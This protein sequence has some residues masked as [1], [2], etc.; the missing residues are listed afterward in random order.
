MRII[1]SD[2]DGTVERFGASRRLATRL[3]AL[4]RRGLLL[5]E[6]LVEIAADEGAQPLR[7]LLLGKPLLDAA[8]GL[9]DK[10]LKKLA[11]GK[12][13]KDNPLAVVGQAGRRVLCLT[14]EAEDMPEPAATPTAGQIV[15]AS[16]NLPAVIARDEARRLL[17]SE[18]VSRLKLDLVTS[19]DAGRRLEALRKLYLSEL[20]PDEKLR[21]FLTA[22]RD[23]DAEVRAEAARALG[24]LGL[25]GALTENLAKA[26]RGATPERVVAI[27]NL[28]R[29]LPRLDANQGKLA[30][31]LL[32]EF[33]A[34]SEEVEVVHAAMGVLATRLAELP[35]GEAIA[36]GLHRKLIELLQVQFARHEDAAR[37]LY[38]ALYKQR[39]AALSPLLVH[40]IDEAGQPALRFFLLSLITEHDLASAAAP[41]VIAL[42]IEG[43]AIGSELDRNYQAATA[44]LARLGERAVDGLL[45][46]LGKGGDNVR[47]RIV[48]L[49]GHLL[50]AGDES[51]Y[52]VQ[53]T[54][55]AR[56]AQ[57]CLALYSESGTD[58][59]TA[60]LD[61]RFYEHRS[62][63][64]ASRRAAAQAFIDSL[65][66]FRFERQLELVQAALVRCGYAGLEPLANALTESAHDVTRLTAARLLPEIVAD[67]PNLAQAEVEALS[68]KL[69]E[70]VDSDEG[71][72]PDRGPIY[73]AL[74]RVCT[75]ARATPAL[76]DSLAAT[77]RERVGL[78][79]NVY[80]ILEAM[81]WLAA[82]EHLSREER[83]EI[84]HL[85]L[86]VLKKGLPG[87][88]GRMRRNAEG[89]HV[90]HFGR[91]TTAYT[92][93]IPRILEGL[94]RMIAAPGTPDVLFES[95]VTELMKLWAE[96][97]EFKRVWAPAATITLARL[98]GEIALGPRRSDRVADEI[99]DLLSRKLVL[100][101]VMQVL[102]KLAI[103]PRESTRMDGIA[104]RT[105]QELAKRL[106]QEPLPEVT[107]R[108]Q[109]LETMAAI[110]KRKR[111]GEREKDLEH[112]RNVVIEAAFEALRDKMFHA[113]LILEDLSRA[114]AFSEQMRAEIARRLKPA[115][116]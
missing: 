15:A 25:D 22:L 69:R 108:R 116:R 94:G 115:Q 88:S 101:P 40:S 49:L 23:R 103:V 9:D 74:G 110:A 2:F 33:L 50:R 39:G 60:L 12:Y 43:L 98:L 105:F 7:D 27:S 73:V 53:P 99:A 75:H 87:M 71:E 32:G 14:E 3:G 4:A 17:G 89:E 63:D 30:I 83:L 91:E 78:S 29:I 64:E 47:A 77:L 62:L 24:G 65:H 81:G 13:F 34:T 82:G 68:R 6:T 55:A 5:S 67:S 41:S 114:E 102:S 113:R 86:T 26:A 38:G 59:A 19:S 56:I 28:S 93:M 44:A 66:E 35:D 104:Q 36:A 107:E 90:L 76:A 48:D 92:D 97:V 79:S 58:V 111:L 109:I 10:S 46:A 95:I 85:L 84:G 16:A 45:S 54:T 112:A 61:S 20:A 51:D 80:D 106:N 1:E 100:L 11:K 18:E 70:I 42:L 57:A 21:L 52:A 37:R 96:I 72:F 31:A 8:D